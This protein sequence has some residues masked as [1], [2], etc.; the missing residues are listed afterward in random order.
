MDE[1]PDLLTCKNLCDCVHINRLTMHL[2]IKRQCFASSLGA[3]YTLHF[4]VR[5]IHKVYPAGITI[6]EALYGPLPDPFTGRG[7][8]T[9]DKALL[10]FL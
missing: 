3:L 1:P 9:M 8:T 10:F 4:C 2:A 6:R 5:K 7:N